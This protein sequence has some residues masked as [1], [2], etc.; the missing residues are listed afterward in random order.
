M[1]EVWKYIDNYN[2]LY[3]ISNLGNVR[4]VYNKK[5]YK[6]LKQYKSNSGYAQVMLYN[7]K[8]RKLEYV[9]RL[10]A[11]AFIP[12]INNYKEVNHID[13]NKLHNIANNLEWC[14]P[15]YNIN[16]GTTIVRRS[17]PRCKPILQ[18]SSD[19][20]LLNRWASAKAVETELGICH[21]SI[22]LCCNHKAFTAGG[23]RW[24]FE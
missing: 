8:K 5:K 2:N 12:N 17:A 19:G 1:K 3:Q 23:Y 7:C 22:G 14:T 15:K 11:S 9:H 6:I 16:Y 21:S 13:E 18:F 10:V 4:S 24:E 20:A